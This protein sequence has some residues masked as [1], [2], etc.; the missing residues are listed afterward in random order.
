MEVTA[1]DAYTE[2]NKMDYLQIT[3]TDEEDVPGALQK[4]RTVYSNLMRLEY[5]NARTTGEPGGSGGGSAGTE[6][7]AGTF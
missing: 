7:R 2:E 6:V 1:K 5:D 4:L 3:L